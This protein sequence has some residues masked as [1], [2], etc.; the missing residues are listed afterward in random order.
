MLTETEAA[1]KEPTWVCAMFSEYILCLFSL[2]IFV[3][4]ITMGIYD[5]SACS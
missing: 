1:M 2:G 5:S 3:V 4:L